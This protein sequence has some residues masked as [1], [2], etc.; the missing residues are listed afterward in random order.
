M[1]SQQADSET[2][3]TISFSCGK[4]RIEEIDNAFAI[5]PR[6]YGLEIRKRDDLSLISLVGVGMASHVGV[7]CKVFG[8]LAAHQI[9]HYH[10]TSSEISISTTID[11]V[12]KA[13]AVVALGETFHL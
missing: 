7:A 3:S 13:E 8:T 4:D 2:T 12:R 5:N 9:P 11:T 1:I 6:L 10:I